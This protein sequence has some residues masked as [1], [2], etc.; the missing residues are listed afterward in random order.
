MIKNNTTLQRLRFEDA[1]FSDEGM[2][3]MLEALQTNTTVKQLNLT[4][5]TT[6]SLQAVIDGLCKLHLKKILIRVQGETQ[7]NEATGK[8]L[9]EA[10]EKSESLCDFT[11]SELKGPNAAVWKSLQP[12]I[13][14]LLSKDSGENGSSKRC[15]DDGGESEAKRTKSE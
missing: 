6:S 11:I 1:S 13:K 12:K 7:F 5:L 3:T 4:C 9:V 10:L 15:L 14:D 2:A 8:S